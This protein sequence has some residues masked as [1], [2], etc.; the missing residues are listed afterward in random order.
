MWRAATERGYK[1]KKVIGV[2]SYGVVVK[3]SKGKQ[4]VAIKHVEVD[5]AQYSLIKILRE[6]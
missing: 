1:I 4:A 6:L 2:G 3:A 5:E